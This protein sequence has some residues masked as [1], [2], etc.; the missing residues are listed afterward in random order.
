VLGLAA[1]MKAEV[2]GGPA[3]VRV[4]HVNGNTH[5]IQIERPLGSPDNPLSR[6]QQVAK[7]RDNAAHAVRRLPASEVDATI[8]SMLRLEQLPD[9]RAA[10]KFLTAAAPQ[11]AVAG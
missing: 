11:S 4:R 8:D 9:A 6:S 2:T 1:T 10:W 7:F 3:A 5:R